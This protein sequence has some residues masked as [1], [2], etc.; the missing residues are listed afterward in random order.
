MRDLTRGGLAAVLYELVQISSSGLIVDEISVPVEDPVRGLCE[1]LGFDP[2]YL[3]NEGKILIV[4]G[5]NEYEKILRILRSHPFGE[6]AAMIGEV[7]TLH[8]GS[9]I[10]N[11]TS[12]WE[13]ILDI[14]CLSLK[15][16]KYFLELKSEFYFQTVV[17]IFIR[18]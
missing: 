11:T 15:V 2:F 10:L 14:P 3:A 18:V 5:E 6:K 1:V 7:T 16:L 17:V 12:G 4:A 13:R 8:K 9:V